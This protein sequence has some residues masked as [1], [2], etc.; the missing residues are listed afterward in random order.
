MNDSIALNAGCLQLKQR[1]IEW[2]YFG[3]GE[4]SPSCCDALALNNDD[5]DDDIIFR[6]QQFFVFEF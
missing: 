2:I 1:Q 5:N 4:H 3:K 6:Y